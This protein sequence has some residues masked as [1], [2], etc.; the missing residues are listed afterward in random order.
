V[1]VFSNSMDSFEDG[2]VLK[3]GGPAPL[4]EQ[5]D[6]N[7]R[8][9]YRSRGI[10]FL[11]LGKIKLQVPRDR[12]GEWNRPGCPSARGTGPGP[13]IS[14]LLQGTVDEKRQRGHENVGLHSV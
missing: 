3:S 8:N 2:R 1:T 12:K 10:N 11:G 6:N 13:Q 14:L 9:G 7:Y 4:D 5:H